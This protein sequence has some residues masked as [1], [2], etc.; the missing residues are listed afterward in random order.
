MEH[1]QKYFSPG[2]VNLIGEHIDYNGGLVMP[3]AL[4]MGIKALYKKNNST[5][6]SLSSTTHTDRIEFHASDIPSVYN[7]AN[8][9]CN[10]PIGVL[11][12]LHKQGLAIEGFD[13][14][15]D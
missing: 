11:S 5:L 14:T 8:S 13:L 4:N 3:I 2:R 1:Q 15:F 9:W 12:A 7:P 6:I 10:Y